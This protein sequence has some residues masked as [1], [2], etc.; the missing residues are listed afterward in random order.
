LFKNICSK[1]TFKKIFETSDWECNASIP[2]AKKRK[3]FIGRRKKEKAK[4][5]DSH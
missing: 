1:K 5:N 2:V 3:R 4:C